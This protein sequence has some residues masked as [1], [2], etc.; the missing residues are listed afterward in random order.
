MA[1][2]DALQKLAGI[3]ETAARVVELRY[4]GGLTIDQTAS[5]LGVS[6]SSVERE[7]RYARSWLYRELGDDQQPPVEGERGR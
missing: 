6:D 2:D 4:F 5:V 1:L 3:K 7:W